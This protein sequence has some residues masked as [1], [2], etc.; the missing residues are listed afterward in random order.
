MWCNAMPETAKVLMAPGKVWLHLDSK[1]NFYNGWKTCCTTQP[2]SVFVPKH[3]PTSRSM[4]G[5][6][7]KHIACYN[8]WQ[9]Q[10]QFCKQLPVP[11]I[12][13]QPHYNCS[14]SAT[15]S[16]GNQHNI[17]HSGQMPMQ[18][19]H[20][21]QMQIQTQVQPQ[22]QSTDVSASANTIAMHVQAVSVP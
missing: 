21:M 13:K 11:Y 18:C 10:L 3:T 20:T 22:R 19:I 15:A 12:C 6:H 5:H 4:H 1:Q 7:T 16:N 8:C 14:A 17:H 9:L 2:S